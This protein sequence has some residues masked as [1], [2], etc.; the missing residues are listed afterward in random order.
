MNKQAISNTSKETKNTQSKKP[1]FSLL[2]M[3]KQAI[4]N[5]SKENK[6][7]PQE[8]KNMQSSEQPTNDYFQPKKPLFSLDRASKILKDEDQRWKYI[9]SSLI[10]EHLTTEKTIE[11][12]FLVN[13]WLTQF[14]RQQSLTK[15]DGQCLLYEKRSDIENK[16]VDELKNEIIE[17]V[18]SI[19]YPS[20]LSDWAW[21]VALFDLNFIADA[22]PY[23]KIPKIIT[24]ENTIVKNIQ[25]NEPRPWR[26]RKVPLTTNDGSTIPTVILWRLNH[27]SPQLTGFFL[28]NLLAYHV[29]GSI[30]TFWKYEDA[31]FEINDF[32]AMERGKEGKVFTKED[33]EV[34]LH[35]LTSANFYMDNAGKVHLFRNAIQEGNNDSGVYPD[36]SNDNSM[37]HNGVQFPSYLHQLLYASISQYIKMGIDDDSYA[38]INKFIDTFNDPFLIQDIEHYS[39][40]L[41]KTKYRDCL[42]RAWDKVSPFHSIEVSGNYYGRY[43]VGEMD[44]KFTD[45]IVDAKAVKD[46]TPEKWF[47]QI[48][49]YRQIGKFNFKK[50]QVISFLDKIIYSFEE[51]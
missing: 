50:L 5:T 8:T 33:K 14:S 29:Y 51:M 35:L 40:S 48:Y 36:E 23:I 6:K 38:A 26:M 34:I 25:E 11:D 49:F 31:S 21:N 45:R 1:L 18:N 22:C 16:T 30:E 20:K 17:H 7:A 2:D 24:D 42:H 12:K 39:Q 10:P 43:M 19:D 37:V 13:M 15:F 28:E 44:Y 41:Q 46:A 27:L 32:D 47:A 4:S 3:N 9:K